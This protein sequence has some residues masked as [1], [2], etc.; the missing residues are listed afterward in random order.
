MDDSS[1]TLTGKFTYI[2]FRNEGNF[3]TAAKFEVNDEKGRVIS[4]TGNIP[5]I[6]T[7]IQYRINGN[8][9]EHP[10]YGM[11]F[12]IQT[13]AKLL[14]TEK[15]GVV[16][17]LSGVNFPS[18]GK[19]TAERVVDVLGEDC[20]TLI[21]EDNAILEKIGDLSERQI[22][23]IIEGLQIDN[24]M[25]ELA[26]FLNIHGLSQ[27]NLS[28][29]TR[30]YG[31]EALSKLNENPY[32]LI[33]E[34]DGFGFKTADKIG[35]SLGISDT[36]NR[37][38]YALL[39]SLVSD[40]CMRDGN[41]YVRLE[42]L[43]TAFFKEL[44][45]LTCDFEA[46]FDEAILKHQIYREDNRV[47]PIAQ[48]DAEICIARFL[49]EF[50]YQ[51][52]DPYDPKLLLSYLEDIQ[53]HLGI[54]YDETQIQAIEV[55]FERPFMIM[56]GGPGTGKTTVVN[57]MIKLFK[58]M[59]PSS[60]II[61]AAPTGRAAKR[62]AEVTGINATT[63]HSLLQW[64]L[65][66]NTFGKN[67]EEPILAD[68]LIVDEFSMVDNWLFYN[69]LLASKRIKKICFIGDK[70]QLPSVGPG[71]VLRDLMQSNEFSLIE[72]KHIYRQESDS[73]VIN[74]A[75]AINTGN[76]NV[77]E[78]HH[79]VKFFA[80]MPEDIRRNILMMV[81][82]ALQK[83]YS[84]D[85]IQILSPMYAGVAGIDYLNNALQEAFNP[86]AKDKAEVKSGYMTFREG[87]KILQLKNQP[88]DDVYNGDIGVLVEIIDA[89]HAEDH[90]TTI[91]CQFGE[92]IVEYKPENWINITL[93]YCISVHKSQGSEYP[94]VIMPITR[95]HAGMLQRKLIYTGVTRARKALIILG[96]LEAFKRGIQVLELHP[97]ETTLTQKLKQYVNGDYGF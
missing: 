96:E 67:D 45:S 40:L 76:V 11:Q 62:L 7:G 78:Y 29:I 2:L 14:P 53:E 17:Y 33:E 55:F 4:V 34:V 5:E 72:L 18:I 13:L 58:L 36:D 49:A 10:R 38:L 74:L 92:I 81:E 89:K 32:R 63:I 15:E 20:L 69:L 82:D 91:I 95:R 66:T 68:L 80:C 90:K 73:D 57:A 97:R 54:T 26:K 46:I 39:V 48:Y 60:S 22:N 31:K 16:R 88:D 8:Y 84:I 79:D 1:I 71:C 37:R 70:D 75:H 83:G 52:I 64:D 50:P 43:E 23:A 56:T 3:Y 21:R 28:K 85:D 9:I 44:G 24:G 6:I 27:R 87:D 47:F 12:Q 59:Y 42:T 25:E 35:K 77:E 61:C 30:I 93:A 65:E 41:S 51:F 19:K 86:P 94:I